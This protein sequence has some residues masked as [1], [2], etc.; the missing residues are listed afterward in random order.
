MIYVK[1]T[2]VYGWK[3]SAS[4]RYTWNLTTAKSTLPVMC[5]GDYLLSE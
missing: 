4:K 2:Q 5:Y 1:Y 3:A